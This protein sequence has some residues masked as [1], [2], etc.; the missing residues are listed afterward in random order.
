MAKQT[1]YNTSTTFKENSK[2]RELWKKYCDESGL[3]YSDFIRK[4][5]YEDN[6]FNKW[7]R[8]GGK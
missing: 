6:K 3:E 7:L 4:S 5:I 1:Y 2:T 8:E